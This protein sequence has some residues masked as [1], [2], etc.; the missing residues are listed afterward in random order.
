MALYFYQTYW[1]V[2][3][4]F[5]QLR[6]HKSSCNVRTRQILVGRVYAEG[7]LDV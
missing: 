6:P 5:H 7:N 2:G 3:P 4:N 1:N